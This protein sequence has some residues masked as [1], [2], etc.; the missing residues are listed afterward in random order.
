MLLLF[1]MLA[2]QLSFKSF[3]TVYHKRST[4][5]GQ[6]CVN[7][8]S[9]YSQFW[10]LHA[11]THTETFCNNFELYLIFPEHLTLKY[12]QSPTIFA[13][14]TAIYFCLNFQALVEFCSWL[15]TFQSYTSAVKMCDWNKYFILGRIVVYFYFIFAFYIGFYTLLFWMC[16]FLSKDFFWRN[17]YV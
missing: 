16:F 17:W 8:S 6:T 1:L 10:F 13:K 11:N 7:L 12:Y 4:L 2:Y 15:Q 14:E 3:A 5:D 9:Y